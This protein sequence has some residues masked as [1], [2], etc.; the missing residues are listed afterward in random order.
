[1]QRKNAFLLS[2]LWIV[3]RMEENRTHSKMKQIVMSF[4]VMSDDAGH[5]LL[6]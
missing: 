4:V 2:A 6:Q 3:D 5:P 1:M